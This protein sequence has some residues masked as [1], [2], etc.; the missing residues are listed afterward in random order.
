MALSRVSTTAGLFLCGANWYRR[1]S[2]RAILPATLPP[3]P[4]AVIHG[5]RAAVSRNPRGRVLPW[6]EPPAS[7]G[8]PAR[9]RAPAPNDS[10][11]S[12]APHDRWRLKASYREQSGQSPYV[13][14]TPQDTPQDTPQLHELQ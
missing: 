6:R 1:I 7:E 4:K 8:A 14:L 10:V 13:D 11:S 12:G 9:R 5:V 3:L 2:P